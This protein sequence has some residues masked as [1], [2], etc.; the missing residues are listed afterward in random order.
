MRAAVKTFQ[1]ALRALRRNVMRSLLTCI[2]IVIGIAAVI[3]MMEIGNGV[4]TLNA[5][6]IASL[7]A[8]NLL[9]LP[10]QAASGGVSWGQGSVMSLTPQDVEAVLRES[11]AVR[12]AAPEVR[13]SGQ[14]IYQNRNWIP[15]QI[16]GTTPSWLDV[17]Q[18]PVDEGAAFTEQD[19][20]NSGKVCLIGQTI[21]RE[22]FGNEDPVGK[23]LRVANVNLKVVG[24]LAR[25]GANM[26]GGVQDDLV[27]APWTT[28]KYRISGKNQGGAGAQAQ[29]SASSGG[30]NTSVNSLSNLYPNNSVSLYPA[31]SPT[32][33][34]DTPQPIR[35]T[36]INSIQTAARSAD[37]VQLAIKQITA[38][39]RERH[40]LRDGEPDDFQ[41]RDMTELMKTMASTTELI[42]KLLLIVAAISLVVGGVGIMNIM[43]V[44]VTERTREI[45]LRMAV[46][47]RSRHILWQFL[48]EAI[49][50][51]LSGGLIGIALGRGASLTVRAT[52][53]WP[54]A[55]SVPAVVVSVLVSAFVGI[56]FGFYPA[57]K[58][59]RLDPI[60]A[61][62]YE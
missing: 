16:T 39:L 25:K 9:V 38:V 53:H 52:L 43:L 34:A 59:S 57:W 60:E 21:A 24:V 3:A 17:R 27:I 1:T 12:A 48:T 2:G 35:F 54:T 58:A 62:R 42:G 8:N 36:N 26:F 56:V 50:L 22:L 30:V 31:Q 37:E 44:S 15:M 46:G 51:C 61:L 29:A 19:V 4:S 40:H 7:G 45:G 6:A 23:D 18:W 11:P 13:G 28:I 47:A 10:G 20:R 5:R 32:Q 14:L 55:L 33:A 41:I 49:V